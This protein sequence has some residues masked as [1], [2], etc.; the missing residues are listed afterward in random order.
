MSRRPLMTTAT[1]RPLIYGVRYTQQSTR[2]VPTDSFV[3][4]RGS[5]NALNGC[6]NDAHCMMFLLK[7]RFQFQ[8]SDLRV[9]TDDQASPSQWP[10][11]ANMFEGF[12][13][14][15]ADA[16][17]GDSLVF[18]YSGEHHSCIRQRITPL[19]MCKLVQ[20]DALMQCLVSTVQAAR[21]IAAGCTACTCRWLSIG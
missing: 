20:V 6:I 8:D 18:H 13:W 5:S 9:L 11:R 19:H 4:C 16:R 17:P 21:S 12:R 3:C 15:A 14:L 7:S 2:H 1:C 10:T